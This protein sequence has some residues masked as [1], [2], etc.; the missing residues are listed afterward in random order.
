MP[1]LHLRR[2][3]SSP[4]A[5][6]VAELQQYRLRRSDD[7]VTSYIGMIIFL[8]SWAM[9]FAALFFAY[10]VVRFRAPFWPPPDQPRL[11]ILLPGLNT[12]VIAASSAAVASAVRASALGRSRRAFVG[13]GAGAVLG[14]VFLLLQ[15]VVWMNLWRAGLLPSSGPYAS[16]FY[17]LT[18][19]HALHVLVGLAALTRLALR[20]R[21]QRTTRTAVRLWGMFWHFVGAVWLVLYLA[22]YVA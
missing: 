7:E 3:S 10:G 12:V 21:V 20:E 18:A 14:A 13:L 5:P 6:D 17:A 11:P 2:V 1:G 9:M 16:V 22:V 4:D 8:A 19:F 15:F